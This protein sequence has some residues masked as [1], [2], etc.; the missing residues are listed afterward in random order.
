MAVKNI[1]SVFLLAPF[2]FEYELVV[3]ALVQ[4]IIHTLIEV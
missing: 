1:F 4:D 3:F 2:L